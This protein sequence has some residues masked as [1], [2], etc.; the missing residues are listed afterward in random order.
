[1]LNMKEQ[2]LNLL[3]NKIVYPEKAVKKFMTSLDI[4]YAKDSELYQ[5]FTQATQ[6]EN[7]CLLRGVSPEVDEELKRLNCLGIVTRL[8]E[9]HQNGHSETVVTR[10]LQKISDELEN[11]TFFGPSAE[12]QIV[13]HTMLHNL[14]EET[15]FSQDLTELE[16]INNQNLRLV[17][18][19]WLLYP[20]LIYCPDSCQE[21]LD[22]LSISD[23]RF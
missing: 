19:Q 8:K 10:Y 18:Q 16:G 7:L 1:M 20:E 12:L 22:A 23:C 6:N 2:I 21:L 17:L 5:L 13:E 4:R 15:K 3:D 9:W 11:P 14:L